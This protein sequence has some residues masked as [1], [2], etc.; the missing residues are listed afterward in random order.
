M[1]HGGRAVVTVTPWTSI[2]IIALRCRRSWKPVEGEWVVKSALESVVSR[3]TTLK[4]DVSRLVSSTQLIC[5]AQQDRNGLSARGTDRSTGIINMIEA[6]GAEHRG[7]RCR[8]SLLDW[9]V[10]REVYMFA[11]R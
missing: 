11:Q 6:G 9:T 2:E 8:C 1:L 7:T 5:C 10:L 4:C 3:E